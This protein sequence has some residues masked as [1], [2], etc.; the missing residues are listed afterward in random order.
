MND[1]D[2]PVDARARRDRRGSRR[3][4]S[5]V[6]VN[7]VVKR[8]VNDDER[9]RRWRGTSA[10]P[11]TSCASSSTWT[12]AR[13]TAGGSTT[14]S[15]PR[16][17]SSA[18]DAEFP[19]EPVE[20]RL[21][22]RGRAALAL[23]RRRGRD[24]RHRVGHAAVLRRLHARADLGR[25]QALHLPVRRRAATTCAR[26]CAAARR[27]TSS[28]RRDRR[29]LDAP[30]RPLLRDPHRR[31]RRPAADRD[32]LHRRLTW[33][34]PWF[35]HEPPPLPQFHARGQLASRPAKP[36]SG[37]EATY[38]RRASAERRRLRFAAGGRFTRPGGQ[39]SSTGSRT[40]RRGLVGEPWVPPRN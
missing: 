2:F 9:R 21:P 33:G 18:I 37:R 5:P 40:R 25:G 4:A 12:S 8:G 13:R 10:A 20:P 38:R 3:P 11:A 16:R 39:A 22:R 24:R 28:A 30:H 29:R 19:L 32:V 14:S 35:P 31:R 26:S 23:P 17:S 1:V 6:K 7:A 27:T 15:R 34:N 36:A